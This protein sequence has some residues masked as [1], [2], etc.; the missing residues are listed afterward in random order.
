M[1]KLL[2]GLL[3][4]AGLKASA[5][6]SSPQIICGNEV[7]SHIIQSNYPDLDEAIRN[8]YQNALEHSG[9]A[10]SRTQKNINVVVHIVW[11]ENEENLADS[12]ILDQ[13]AVLNAA[14]NRLNPDTANLRD[15]F[16]PVAGNADIHFNLAGVERVHTN[17]LFE[18]SLS[19]TNLLSEVKSS[20]QGGSDAWDTD[21]FLNIWVCK[22]QPLG[23]GGI[24]LGQILGFAFPPADL[25]NWPASSNA[26]TPTED[27]VVIDFRVFGS[28]NPNPLVQQGQTVVVKGRTSVHEVGHYLG[29]RHI[30]GD[31]GLL[32]L[33]NDCQQSDGVDDTP[34][35]NAQSSQD[36]DLS[37]NTC[38]GIDPFYGIDVPDL[39][40]NYMDY[41]S[42]PC[43]T[44]FTK[45]Q[46]ALMLSVLEGPRA[47]LLES[48]SGT[49]ALSNQND[50]QVIP[51]PVHGTA[52]ITFSDNQ[53]QGEK[54][55]TLYAINGS[56]M[57]DVKGNQQKF[58]LN[59][60]HLQDG[61]YLMQVL[62][63]NGQ[64][65]RKVVIQNN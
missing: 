7:F 15:I 48:V 42:E 3:I 47:A 52:M 54:S 14:Y 27:G 41:S 9:A 51:N 19:G 36:C 13:I 45:G 8:T 30:W 43:Q 40:E 64:Y 63:E 29:L 50:W 62:T 53:N 28:N 2:L 32:G 56:K 65:T 38:D 46:V 55:I 24:E 23:F 12:V 4:L 49:T 44:M 22:I 21:H 20:T 33:P 35:A 16:K 1:K 59:T 37:K 34:F 5:Q 60:Q 6:T 57:I 58:E 17:Q 10:A 61:I 31:G 39:V 25:P 26:P 18:V 11:K